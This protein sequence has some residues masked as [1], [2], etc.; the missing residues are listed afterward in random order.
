MASKRKR[1]CKMSV[2][3]E[4][5]IRL[6][7]RSSVLPV[8]AKKIDELHAGALKNAEAIRWLTWGIRGIYASAM[9]CL[10]WFNFLK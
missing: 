3:Q 7:E 2:D 9:G 4:L 10:G 8:L 6:D 5:L 1:A